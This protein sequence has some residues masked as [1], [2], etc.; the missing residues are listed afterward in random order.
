MT[1]GVMLFSRLTCYLFNNVKW[2]DWSLISLYISL[3]SGIIVG[4]QYDLTTPFYSTAAIDALV[5]FGEYFRS[6]HF[7]SSQLFFLMAII[8]YL[9]VFNDLENYNEKRRILL[10]LTLPVILMLLFTGYVLRG[11]TTGS[12]AGMIAEN[13]VLSVPLIGTF[14][15]ELLFS[16][17]DHG[18]NRVYMHHVISFDILFLVMAWEHLRRYRVRMSAYPLFIACL[19]LFCLFIAAP[20]D[21]EEL[22]TFY[23]TGPWFFLGLQELLRYFHPFIAGVV[24]PLLFIVALT[25]LSRKK[26]YYRYLLFF[27]FFWLIMYLLLTLV[28]L[29][30]HG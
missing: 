15:N 28:A 9:S 22:G 5:P 14:L 18:M 19:L 23:I 4:L 6:L 20:I 2:G 11:D 10:V 7:Y 26:S 1:L 8:H 17:T 13:I 21:P 27:I 3:L 16:I 30:A 25:L 29:F 12:S 24:T